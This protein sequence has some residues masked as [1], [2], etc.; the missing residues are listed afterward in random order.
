MI[1][2]TPGKVTALDTLDDFTSFL[3]AAG[4]K[5]VLIDFHA[6]WC[7][8]CKQISPALEGMAVEM[9]DVAFCKIDVDVNKHV[10]SMYQISS[11]P[12]FIFLRHGVVANR[13]SGADPNR[14]RGILQNLR[15]TGYDIIPTGTKVQ[16]HGLTGAP[17]HNGL[18][19]SVAAYNPL[20]GRYIVKASAHDGSDSRELSLKRANILQLISATLVSSGE[21]ATLDGVGT[22]PGLYSLTVK[23][24]LSSVELPTVEFTLT[25][26][27]RCEVA[28]L[29]G[30]AQYN[31]K[32]GEVVSFDEDAGR[33]VV[34][35]ATN[36]QL[37]LKKDNVRL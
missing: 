15:I 18:K 10:A 31:G 21:S 1:T 8:P 2:V 26:G 5:I 32:V 22:S 11:M 33:Y 20:K 14:L 36:K 6:V 7:G 13:F 19:G 4:D 34:Q 16:V 37:K 28:G 17:Q 12:T 3:S 23:K 27:F 9:T 24:D 30:A 29:V 35:V 25:P